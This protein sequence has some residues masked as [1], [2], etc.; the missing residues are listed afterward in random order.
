[1]SFWS[2]NTIRHE[3]LLNTLALGKVKEDRYWE[4]RSGPNQILALPLVPPGEVRIILTHHPID[5]DTGP[6]YIRRLLNPSDVAKA[7]RRSTS[8]PSSVS[9]V[10]LV[11][12]GH[13]HEVYPQIGQGLLAGATNKKLGP[14]QLQLTIGSLSQRVLN[15]SSQQQSFQMIRLYLESPTQGSPGS[16]LLVERIVF[17]RNNN[18]SYFDTRVPPG[19][20]GY[21]EVV[22][23]AL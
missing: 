21:S 4:P 13:T 9:P 16:N 6:R 19:A 2:L 23:L 15:Q 11:L 20:Q 18:A 10:T 3:R 7:L 14:N 22:S 12:S 8:L 1:V 17:F 5:G